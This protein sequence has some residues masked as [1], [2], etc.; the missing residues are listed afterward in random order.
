MNK[1][2]NP[3][4]ETKDCCTYSLLYAQQDALTHNKEFS[5]YWVSASCAHVTVNEYNNPSFAT[6]FERALLN[7]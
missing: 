6:M 1:Y 4:F 2:N 3:S 7:K 5:L